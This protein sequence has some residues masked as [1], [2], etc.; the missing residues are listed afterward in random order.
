MTYNRISPNMRTSEM[1][2]NMLRFHGE[3]LLVP[4][5]T[6]KDHS[7]SAARDCVFNI[8]AA[9]LHIWKPFL[10]PQSED[11]PCSGDRDPTYHGL[12]AQR[13]FN[14][15]VPFIIKSL[16]TTN[17]CPRYHETGSNFRPLHRIPART[18]GSWLA[19]RQKKLT[20]GVKCLLY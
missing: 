18:F 12:H 19:A 15:S 2:R 5:P 7:L 9:T 10:H 1:F 3:E 6:P 16:V 13:F 11:A 4:S 20:G 14:F 8:F 17:L